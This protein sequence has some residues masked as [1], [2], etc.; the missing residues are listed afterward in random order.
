LKLDKEKLSE[1]FAVTIISVNRILQ[2]LKSK[3]IID[4]KTNSIIIKDFKQLTLE[5]EASRYE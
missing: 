4:I 2:S 3:N 1:K 5:E